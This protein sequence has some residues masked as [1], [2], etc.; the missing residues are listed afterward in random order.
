M[1]TTAR[2]LATFYQALLGGHLLR[3][4]TLAVACEPSSEGDLDRT[5]RMPIRWSQ[6]FQLGGPRWI[7]GAQ[8]AL[9]SL[10][11]PRTFGHNGSNCCIGWA[12]PDRRIAYAYLTNRVGRPT[13]DLIHH[14]AV[15]DKVLEAAG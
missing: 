8:T 15:A 1:S 10:S 9:G 14:A 2:E 13:P 6:G 11:S 3:P 7:E 12:D 4:E 5:A